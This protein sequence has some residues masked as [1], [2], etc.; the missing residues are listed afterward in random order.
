MAKGH[1]S[2]KHWLQQPGLP[3]L[4]DAWLLQ[5]T[6]LL[7]PPGVEMSLRNVG[8]KITPGSGVGAAIEYWADT[9][10][11]IPTRKL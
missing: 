7:V 9:S 11:V 2:R 1:E 8:V 5:H 6:E 4:A 3:L 10:K